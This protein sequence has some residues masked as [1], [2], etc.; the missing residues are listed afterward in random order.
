MIIK[1]SAKNSWLRGVKNFVIIIILMDF[2][3]IN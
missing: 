3:G 1:I 2:R